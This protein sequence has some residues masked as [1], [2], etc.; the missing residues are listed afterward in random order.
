MVTSS[1]NIQPF[2]KCNFIVL[3]VNLHEIE[4]LK[5]LKEKK[6]LFDFNKHESLFSKSYFHLMMTLSEQ[7]YVVNDIRFYMRSIGAK[8]ASL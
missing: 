5:R 8:E 6:F 3:R 4:R 1:L 7:M 2:F